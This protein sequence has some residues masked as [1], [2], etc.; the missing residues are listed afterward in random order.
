MVVFLPNY[1]GLFCRHSEINEVIKNYT[2]NP[3]LV[4]IDAN[5]TDELGIP[6]EAYYSVEKL[7][8]VDTLCVESVFRNLFIFHNKIVCWLVTFARFSCLNF[9]WLNSG[10][11]TDFCI[12]FIK[13]GKEWRSAII[14]S[15]RFQYRGFGGWRDRCW[16]SAAG[17]SRMQYLVFEMLYVCLWNN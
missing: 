1:D 2:P 7:A 11:Q 4:I 9:L 8:E 15:H 10:P 17:Y 13:S 14:R 16:T 6:T 12:Y 5:P 3:V